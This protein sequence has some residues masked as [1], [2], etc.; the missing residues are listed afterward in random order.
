M[1]RNFKRIVSCLS[2]ILLTFFLFA[3]LNRTGSLIILW[4]EDSP[5]SIQHD[6]GYGY[7][8]FVRDENVSKLKLPVYLTEDDKILI[9]PPV[10]VN[11]DKL[12]AIKSDG[13]GRYQMLDNNDLYF[14][15]SDNH[16]ENHEYKIISPAV[17]RNRYL[18]LIFF[19]VTLVLAADLFLSLRYKD[20][21]IFTLILRGLTVICLVMPAIP[22]NQLIFSGGPLRIGT[23]LIRPVLQR[24]C[25]FLCLL[26]MFILLTFRFWGKKRF[27]RI[28]A[29]V[30]ILLNTVYFFMPEWNFFGRRADSGDYL[31]HYSASSI[32]TPGYPM[33]IETVYKIT[34]NNGLETLRAEDEMLQDENLRDSRIEDSSGL[35][36]VI[37][38]QKC[39]LAVFFLAFFAVFCRYYNS[40]W[41]L[42][43]A[44]IILCYGFLGV[45]NSYIM[46]ECLSQAAILFCAAM[47][48]LTVKEKKACPFWLLCAAA[49]VGILIRPANIFL[50]LLIVIGA[51]V[52]IYAKRSALIWIT[53]G[54]VFLCISAV[55]AW[56][57]YR[58]YGMFVW[59]PTSG[60]VE[61]A[62]AV[63]L[64]QPGDELAFDD[65]ELGGF[66]RDILE[67][68][69]AYPGADQNTNMWQVAVAAAEERGYDHITCSPLFVKVSRKIFQ[70]HFG[71]FVSSLAETIKTALERTRL[72]LGPIPFWALA[73][74]F[75]V[76]SVLNINE[77]SAAGLIFM[78]LH[79]AHLCI[80][81]MNQPER[82]YIYSTEIFCLL[83]WLLIILHLAETTCRRS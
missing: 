30:I 13:G 18:L 77:G 57:I 26:F 39:V 43:G 4:K 35:I 37:R 49:G 62:R 82:R 67:K 73:V 29:V 11:E 6:T 7:Y 66:C 52:L 56:T 59:M 40:L 24:N 55:P 51:G 68:K 27:L 53:G 47:F 45:D 81:M 22:W 31:Q 20:R 9:Q 54:L 63:S 50:V 3:V 75:S 25:I 33:F 16:P 41:F 21:E 14:S 46:S 44:Q 10:S 48:L 36:D 12:A 38:S 78:L 61:I 64:V 42:F 80:S 69:E 28:L 58:Q 83:G 15:A 2:V 23:M 65:P 70:K 72:Q 76:L 60:Y 32:R 34:G 17:I 19:V 5:G 71:E 74:L 1:N 8:A 79:I